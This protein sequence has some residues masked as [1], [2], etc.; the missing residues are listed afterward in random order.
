MVTCLILALF[1]ASS[2][3]HNKSKTD[4]SPMVAVK[5]TGSFGEKITAPGSDIGAYQTDGS[6]NQP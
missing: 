5:T 3:G 1:K 6:G 2:P 4:F